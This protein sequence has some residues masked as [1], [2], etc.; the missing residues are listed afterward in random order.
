MLALIAQGC[1]E[2]QPVF[3]AYARWFKGKH[4][5]VWSAG[6]RSLLLGNP[7]EQS[8]IELAE[9]IEEDIVILGKLSRE[10]WAVVLRNDAR[11]RLLEVARTG[12]WQS[13]VDFLFQVE[14]VGGPAPPITR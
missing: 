8:D 13:V 6:L 10:Q 11:G 12:D 9:E 5:L 3:L 2:L 1:D 14:Y 4:Q 7:N